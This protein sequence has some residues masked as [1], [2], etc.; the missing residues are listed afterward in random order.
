M[1]KWEE[2]SNKKDGPNINTI[3]GDIFTFYLT[4]FVKTWLVILAQIIFTI[5]GLF[6]PSHR[7]MILTQKATYMVEH[8]HS[9][10]IG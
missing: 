4:Y 7:K 6:F 8:Y 1:P 5:E 9:Q 2:P 3:T 10:Q